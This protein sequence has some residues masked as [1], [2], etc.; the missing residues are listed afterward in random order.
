MRRKAAEESSMKYGELTL[1]QVEAIVNKLGGMDG[2]KGFLSGALVVTKVVVNKLLEFVGT[3]SV[4]AAEKFVTA[5]HFKIDTSASAEVKIGCLGHEFHSWFLGKT[6]EPSDETELQ[7]QRLCRRSLD[8]PILDELGN[9]A[10]TTLSMIWELLKLQPNGESGSPLTNANANIF[11][12]R[13]AN[14]VL[15]AVSVYWHHGCGGWG[16]DAFSIEY[17]FGWGWHSDIRVFSRNFH[18][19]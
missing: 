7:Y 9:A 4:S 3:V 1:G 5:D 11:Y 16:V 17:P 6:E 12:V 13:D 10:E 18:S 8:Q 14:G 15:R 2:V 19:A